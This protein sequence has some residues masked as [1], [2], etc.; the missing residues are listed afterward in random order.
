MWIPALKL[1]SDYNCDE[2]ASAGWILA[3]SM[4]AALTKRLNVWTMFQCCS[5]QCG[6]VLKAFDDTALDIDPIFLCAAE[7]PCV[8]SMAFQVQHQDDV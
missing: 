3:V 1:S 7:P 6:W 5:I 8:F 4:W 2:Q